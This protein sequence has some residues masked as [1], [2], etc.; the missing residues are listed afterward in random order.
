MEQL[1]TESDSDL[2]DTFS[3][4]QKKRYFMKAKII[5][6]GSCFVINIIYVAVANRLDYYNIFTQGI[7]MMVSILVIWGIWYVFDPFKNEPPA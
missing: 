7:F 2:G 1:I 6:F 4:S 5:V 3:N